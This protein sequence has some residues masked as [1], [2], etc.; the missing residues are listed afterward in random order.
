MLL[1]LTTPTGGK[2]KEHSLTQETGNSNE[3]KQ[4]VTPTIFII[5][6]IRKETLQ[7]ENKKPQ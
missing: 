6:G 1:P 2:D 7:R 4:A 5:K 3:L